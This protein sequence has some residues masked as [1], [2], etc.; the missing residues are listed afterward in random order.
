MP[1]TATRLVFLR[2]YHEKAI[3]RSHEQLHRVLD[4]LYA[5]D[6]TEGRLLL[7]LAKT[8]FALHQVCAGPPTRPRPSFPS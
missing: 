8:E 3:L 1:L 7:R 5:N 6:E 4:T 2:S